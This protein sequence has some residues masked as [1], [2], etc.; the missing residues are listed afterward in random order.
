MSQEAAIVA[1]LKDGNQITVMD[2]IR[3]FDCYA[4]S[5]RMTDA[6]RK[7]IKVRSTMIKVASGKR[8]AC[9][10]ISKARK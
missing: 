2:A 4:L 9:Y 7:G 3:K 10:W 5:Q 1:Y 8:V 6:K